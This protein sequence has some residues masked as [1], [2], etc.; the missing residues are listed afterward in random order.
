MKIGSD[1]NTSEKW[2]KT[3]K[4]TTVPAADDGMSLL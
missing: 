1:L 4:Q 3:N 2:K